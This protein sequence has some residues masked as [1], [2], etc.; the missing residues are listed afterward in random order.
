MPPDIAT[1]LCQP[2]I[3]SSLPIVAE[4]EEVEQTIATNRRFSVIHRA[5]Q[6]HQTRNNFA[7]MEQIRFP[8]DPATFLDFIGSNSGQVEYTPAINRTGRQNLINQQADPYDDVY[9]HFVDELNPPALRLLV[10]GVAG[11]GKTFILT[12]IKHMLDTLNI[13]YMICSSTGVSSFLAKG[14]YKITKLFSQKTSLYSV[15]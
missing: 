11:S 5:L 6:T 2:T 8:T 4:N 7:R 9:R 15:I 14:T 10:H 12:S 1:V 13:A 3:S